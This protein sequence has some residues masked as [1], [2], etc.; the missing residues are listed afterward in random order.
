MEKSELEHLIDIC[1]LTLYDSTRIKVS[2][3]K[4][5]VE[6]YRP[7]LLEHKAEIISIL[8]EQEAAN[9]EALRVHAEKVAAIEGLAE[10]NQLA[11][12][13]SDYE[14]AFSAFINAG[15]EGK[16]PVKPTRLY[17]DVAAKYPRAVAYRKAINFSSAAHYAKAGAG[18]RAA[19]RILDGEDYTAAI[20]DMEQ[21]WGDHC[22]A[23]IFD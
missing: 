21:E 15:A 4:I 19:E 13:W 7:V 18:R 20:S 2:G 3:P 8:E 11:D 9:A 23:H 16:S 12:A 17:A 22:D 6:K 10:L 1:R 14:Y 5:T